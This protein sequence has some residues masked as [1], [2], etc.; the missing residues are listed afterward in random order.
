MVMIDIV[1]ANSNGF[2]LILRI[3]DGTRTQRDCV[4]TLSGIWSLQYKTPDAPS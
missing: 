2:D 1:R 4:V 3:K